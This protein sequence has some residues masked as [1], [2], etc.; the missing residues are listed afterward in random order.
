MRYAIEEIEGIG[1]TYGRKLKSVGIRTTTAL[2]AA[3]ADRKGRK[4]L[5]G[6]TGIDE[7]QLLKWANH[8]DLMRIKGIGRQYAELLEAAGVDTVK[9][10]KNR[11]AT[12]LAGTMSDVNGKKRLTRAVPSEKRVQG[13]IEHAKS[14]PPALSYS[15]PRPPVARSTRAGRRPPPDAHGSGWR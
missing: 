6:S 2:L 10:L 1:S 5:A 7:G 15:E 4:D 12:N 8:A 14:L 13:W 3:C 9:E 11:N